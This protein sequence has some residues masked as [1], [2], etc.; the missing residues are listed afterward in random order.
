MRVRHVAHWASWADSLHMVR[1]RHP[2]VAELMI[3]GLQANAS[4][5]CLQWVRRCRQVVLDAGLEM[6]PWQELADSLPPRHEE[7]EP[8]QPH[9]GWQQRASRKLE[10]KFL[11]EE[12]W[13]GLS[14]SSRAL[15]SQHGPLASASLTV[16]PT[17]KALGSMPNPFVSSCADACTCPSFCPCADV[18]TNLINLAI[19]EQRAPWQGC[20]GEGAARWR[21]LRPKCAERLELEFPPTSTSETWTW[22]SS[23]TWTDGVWSRRRSHSLGHGQDPGLSSPSSQAQGGR[24]QWGSIG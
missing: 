23:T 20:W 1:T 19:I 17:S 15:R 24:P 9:F 2:G 8:T 16:L 18:A 5:T 10:E 22:Q 4:L 13:P 14:D 6:P 21:S 12:V 11:R 3:N 7:P